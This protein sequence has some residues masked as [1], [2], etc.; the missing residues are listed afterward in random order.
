MKKMTMA[1]VAG[2]ILSSLTSYAQVD[3]G[4]ISERGTDRKIVIQQDDKAQEVIYTLKQGATNTELNRISF[5]KENKEL[6]LKGKNNNYN[7]KLLKTGF[8][9]SG[10]YYD[11]CWAKN[12]G[13]G[14]LAGNVLLYSTAVGGGLGLAALAGGGALSLTVLGVGVGT[15]LTICGVLPA[16]PAL[17]SIATLPADLVITLG[18]KVEGVFNKKEIAA[19]KFSKAMAGKD[20]KA[21]KRVFAELISGIENL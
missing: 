13:E 4:S 15:G 17:I 3:V 16:M 2:L 1:L 11:R 5:S 18:D 6:E 8:K 7:F 19:R 14:S 12:P 9:H 21:S 10:K 20:K